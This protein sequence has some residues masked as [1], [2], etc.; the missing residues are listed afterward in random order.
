MYFIFFELSCGLFTWMT[1]FCLLGYDCMMFMFGME[2]KSYSLVSVS[3]IISLF[4][5]CSWSQLTIIVLFWFYM[6]LQFRVIIF[7]WMEASCRLLTISVL[8]YK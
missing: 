2:R 1:P 6:L 4:W 3:P 7:S 8:F 5:I